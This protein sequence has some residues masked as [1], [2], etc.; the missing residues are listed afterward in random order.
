MFNSLANLN[1]VGKKNY[2]ITKDFLRK[3]PC[4]LV[5][6]WNMAGMGAGSY[7]AAREMGAIFCLYLGDAQPCLSFRVQKPYTSIRLLEYLL[8]RSAFKKACFPG[9]N[10]M[11]VIT[12]SQSLKQYL[13]NNGAPLDRCQVILEGLPI[14]EYPFTPFERNFDQ[15]L[16]LFCQTDNAAN[17]GVFVL[18][19]ALGRLMKEGADEFV[20]TLNMRKDCSLKE[21]VARFLKQEGL[22]EKVILTDALE[23]PFLPRMLKKQ[24]VY[25]SASEKEEPFGPDHLEAMATGCAVISDKE[26]IS[27]L[28]KHKQTGIS[29]IS[30][31]AEDLRGKVKKL[32]NNESLRLEIIKRARERVLK[33]HSFKTYLNQLENFMAAVTERPF[34]QTPK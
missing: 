13:L 6:G 33:N 9:A 24:H 26:G 7:W 30:G 23:L 11:P 15:E 29:F 25:I 21:E 2:K 32:M 18:L 28:V 12:A 19:D 3:N 5:F 16:R 1:R 4:D 10:C 17:R 20:L 22:Q 27:D 8:E 14:R 34:K 31:D